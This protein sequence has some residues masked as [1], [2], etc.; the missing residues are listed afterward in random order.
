MAFDT[1]TIRRSRM[2]EINIHINERYC[3]ATP[4]IRMWIFVETNELQNIGTIE[5]LQLSIYS[6]SNIFEKLISPSLAYL[7]YVTNY[8][9]SSTIDKYKKKKR[10]KKEKKSRQNKMQHRTKK[11]NTKQNFKWLL[12]E[13]GF[14]SFHTILNNTGPLDHHTTFQTHK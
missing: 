6:S 7:M 13:N 4:P 9:L 11:W 2:R 1:V 10:E 3:T 5:W 12:R 8:C 14:F